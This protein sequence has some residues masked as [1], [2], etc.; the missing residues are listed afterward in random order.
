MRY[1]F[2][3]NVPDNTSIII[4]FET[5]CQFLKYK[6][7]LRKCKSQICINSTVIIGWGII[8]I[9]IKAQ[10]K[11]KIKKHISWASAMYASCTPGI[12]RYYYHHYAS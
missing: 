3:W 1:K 5:T 6:R 11:I 4:K 7:N 10:K 9:K 2:E 12:R 8:V